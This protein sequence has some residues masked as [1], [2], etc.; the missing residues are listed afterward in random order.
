MLIESSLMLFTYIRDLGQKLIFSC[1]L[2]YPNLQGVVSNVFIHHLVPWFVVDREVPISENEI[3]SSRHLFYVPVLIR[4]AN[5]ARIGLWR[6]QMG[7][8]INNTPV[9]LYMG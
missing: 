3:R 7:D 1:A 9:N 6:V 8:I 2:S 4:H 5:A